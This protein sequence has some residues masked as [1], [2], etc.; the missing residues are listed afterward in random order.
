MTS[1]IVK[2]LIAFALSLYIIGIILT[3]TA[4]I[5]SQPSTLKKLSEEPSSADKRSQLRGTDS[6]SLIANS[7]SETLSSSINIYKFTDPTLAFKIL[8]Q[9][10]VFKPVPEAYFKGRT[11]G[12]SLYNY[13]FLGLKHDDEYCQKHRAYIVE[14]PESIF[15]EINFLT[16]W[17]HKSIV[18]S[19]A[20]QPIAN[21][22]QPNI[23]ALMPKEQKEKQTFDLKPSLNTFI[24]TGSMYYY[25]EIGKHFSCLTQSSN[26]ILGSS[27][28][29]RKDYVAEAMRNYVNLFQ[30]R[31]QCLNHDKFFP[32][33]WLLYEK[34]DCEDFFTA[35]NSP[36]Y[37]RLQQERRIVYIRKVG[38][39]GHRGEGVQPVNEQEEADLR[40][41]YGNG[42]LCGKVGQNYIIQHYVHNPIL[43]NGNKFDFRM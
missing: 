18:R 23:H 11:G 4:A 12:N 29:F 9:L 25:H 2:V 8:S 27:T 28:L 31:P 38:S 7:L 24:A 6:P 16:E 32:Y 41:T 42:T 36:D 39:G 30:D 37:K 15:E 17:S 20:I 19:K 13:T 43:L 34:Q 22:V 10:D 33:T 5:P 14:Y 1:P 40:Q 21:D 3:Y 35:L 26:Q